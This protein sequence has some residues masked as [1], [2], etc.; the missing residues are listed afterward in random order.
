[1]R[2]MRAGVLAGRVLARVFAR[3][4][5]ADGRDKYIERIQ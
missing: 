4:G 1:M 2:R 5:I 3:D